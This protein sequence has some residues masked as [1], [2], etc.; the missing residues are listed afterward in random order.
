MDVLPALRIPR[1]CSCTLTSRYVG[2]TCG[3]L[4]F[5]HM[6][7]ALLPP[8]SRNHLKPPCLQEASPAHYYLI[9]NLPDTRHLILLL[10]FFFNVCHLYVINSQ[11]MFSELSKSLSFLIV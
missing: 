7:L 4:F 5:P 2:P 3:H 10:I 9:L 8:F 1:K 11:G 6:G